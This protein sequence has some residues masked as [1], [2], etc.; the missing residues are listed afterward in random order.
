[1]KLSGA[2]SNICE[3]LDEVK[4]ALQSFQIS[5][6]LLCAHSL[7]WQATPNKSVVLSHSVGTS[8]TLWLILNDI[9][10]TWLLLLGNTGKRTENPNEKCLESRKQILS[11]QD[12]RSYF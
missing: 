7:S 3:F 8:W 2:S 9:T 11:Y 10:A 12:K 6:R 4:I 5:L 1:M